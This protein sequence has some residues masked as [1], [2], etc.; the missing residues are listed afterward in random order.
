M[1]SLS[2]F[3]VETK[4]SV[5]IEKQFA[6]SMSNVCEES[7]L[8][9]FPKNFKRLRSQIIW[10]TRLVKLQK[11]SKSWCSLKKTHKLLSFKLSFD[12]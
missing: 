11:L 2:L 10:V 7:S 1:L 4:K 8:K 3:K 6:G 9:I 5:K 12:F